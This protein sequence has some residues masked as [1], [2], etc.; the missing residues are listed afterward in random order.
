MIMTHYSQAFLFFFL[1]ITGA[2]RYPMALG[3]LGDLEEINPV[4]GHPIPEH[5][6]QEGINT[7]RKVYN[8]Q[9]V[10]PYTYLG[11]HHYRHKRYAL[12]IHSWA[13]ASEVIRG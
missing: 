12:A 6:Y 5:F 7:A 1:I 11:A 8:N 2:G 13:Q 4:A 9:H 10:Y 3:N